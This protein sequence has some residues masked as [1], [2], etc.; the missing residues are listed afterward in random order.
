MGPLS[1]QDLTEV[2]DQTYICGRYRMI[3]IKN[4]HFLVLETG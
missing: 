2:L 1:H 4:D 3:L